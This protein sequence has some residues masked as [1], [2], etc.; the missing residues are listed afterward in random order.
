MWDKRVVS[1]CSVENSYQ[2]NFFVKFTKKDL[3]NYSFT[4]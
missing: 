3:K 1:D 4:H 2:V